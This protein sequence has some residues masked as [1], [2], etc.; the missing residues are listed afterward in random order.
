MQSISKTLKQTLDDMTDAEVLTVKESEII[1][2]Q[3]PSVIEKVLEDYLSK[4]QH[5]A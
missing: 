2:R 4:N 3:L 5:K 1:L